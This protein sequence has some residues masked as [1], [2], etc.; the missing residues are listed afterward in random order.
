[1]FDD[2]HLL[3]NFD[4]SRFAKSLLRRVSSLAYYYGRYEF[5]CDYKELSRQ[6]DA[7]ICAENHFIL[8]T[9]RNRRMS[10]LVGDG[11]FR[12]DFSGLLPFLT[13]GLYVHTGKGS[14]FGMGGY[15]L[16]EC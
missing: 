10:G 16:L 5:S 12:G 14:S 15:E 7:V 4:F 13:A 3:H 1:L 11:S 6:A 9:D 8:A 2:G